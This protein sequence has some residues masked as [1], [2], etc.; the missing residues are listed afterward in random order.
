MVTRDIVTRDIVTQ[1]VQLPAILQSAQFK[2]DTARTASWVCL[3]CPNDSIIIMQ[4]AEDWFHPC[5]P[6]TWQ[7]LVNYQLRAHQSKSLLA[8]L[9]LPL[10][11]IS[12]THTMIIYSP[13]EIHETGIPNYWSHWLCLID[14]NYCDVNT[15]ADQYLIRKQ[16]ALMH[17]NSMGPWKQTLL[18][19]PRYDSL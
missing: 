14:S 6:D 18:W 9:H 3:W 4:S 2:Q 8:S 1:V 12:T 17:C 11:A 13:L 15:N 7:G 5:Q 10:C 19:L 16:T